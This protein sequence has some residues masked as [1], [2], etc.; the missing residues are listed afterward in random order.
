MQAT[1]A[2]H[3]A[4]QLSTD[5]VAGFTEVSA[6]GTGVGGNPLRQ[7]QQRGRLRMLGCGIAQQHSLAFAAEQRRRDGP[8]FAARVGWSAKGHTIPTVGSFHNKLRSCSGN[9]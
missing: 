5:A 2:G 1:G 6:A 3:S 8:G 9:Q 7:R 4:D